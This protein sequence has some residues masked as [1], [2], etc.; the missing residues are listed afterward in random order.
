M[1]GR[2]VTNQEETLALPNGKKLITLVSKLP[3]LDG[4]RVLGIV[5]YFADITSLK[6][7]ERELRQAKR[8]AEAANQAKSVFIANI[9]HDSAHALN[10]ACWAWRQ[11]CSRRYTPRRAKPPL[12]DL[13][14]VR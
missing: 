8:Q 5:G 11:C 4:N 10:R 14:Q 2:P 13:L 6:K 12:A 1:A 7:K 3:I 9:S